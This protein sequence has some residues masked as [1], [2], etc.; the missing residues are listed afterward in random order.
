MQEGEKARTICS[1][2][3]TQVMLQQE[4][5]DIGLPPGP[6]QPVSEK[7]SLSCNLRVPRPPHYLED[8]QWV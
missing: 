8:G 2:P 5:W 6:L 1:L 3:L 7:C 4:P